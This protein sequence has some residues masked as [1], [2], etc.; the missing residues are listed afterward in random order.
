MGHAM[1]VT[2]E[3]IIARY[4]RMRGRSVL[5]LP[6]TDHAGA[7]CPHFVPLHRDLNSV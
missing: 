2:L 6:G 1:F 3:D 4:Q 7:A 5:W